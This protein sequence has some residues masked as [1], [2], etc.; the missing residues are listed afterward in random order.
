MALTKIQREGRAARRWRESMG[1]SRAAA[2]ELTG[3]N[4]TSIRE[5]ENGFTTRGKEP[6]SERALAR[7]KL[8]CAAVARKLTEWDWDAAKVDAHF[9]LYEN[10]AQMLEVE[11]KTFQNPTNETDYKARKKFIR[12]ALD[13]GYSMDFVGTILGISRQQIHNIVKDDEYGA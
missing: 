2:A 8:A 3:Y 13:R 5:F 6:V 9:A 7:Y 12:R 11:A 10:E 4:E 1:L